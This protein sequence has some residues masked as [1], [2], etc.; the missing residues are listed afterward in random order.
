MANALA[1]STSALEAHCEAYLEERE[2]PKAGVREKLARFLPRLE[3]TAAVWLVEDKRD[4]RQFEAVAVAPAPPDVGRGDA[5]RQHRFA[6]QVELRW[7]VLDM[8][9]RPPEQ[10]VPPPDRPD[11][12]ECRFDSTEA[13][14]AGDKPTDPESQ[15]IQE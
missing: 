2:P 4:V 7:D 9:E 5:H 15:S 6:W 14:E 10:V 13:A 11:L 1:R 8:L 3:F 12:A